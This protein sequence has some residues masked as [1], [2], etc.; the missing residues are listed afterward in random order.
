MSKTK[1]GL[2]ESIFLEPLRGH[3]S[4]SGTVLGEVYIPPASNPT[5]FCEIYEELLS[6]I[7]NCGSNVIIGAY[8]NLDLLRAKEQL[9]TSNF[10]D[11]N[12]SSGITP[13]QIRPTRVTLRTQR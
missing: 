1:P 10:I 7:A 12:F 13:T 6:K 9:D 2:F 3:K 11:I 4:K 8:Q 5:H